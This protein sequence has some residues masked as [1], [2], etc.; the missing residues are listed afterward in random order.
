MRF[1]P[2]RVA[3]A[4]TVLYR[5]WVRSM[6]FQ[7]SNNLDRIRAC[8][9][10][11]RPILLAIWHEELFALTGFGT[12]F[13]SG[14][15][16]TVVSDSRDGELIAQVLRR[17]GFATARGSSTRGGLKALNQLRRHMIDGRIGV[18]T[19]D[20]PRGPRQEAKDGAVYLAQKAG[21][22]LFPVRSRP[23]SAYV[24]KRSWDHF[25]LPL[26]F[27]ACEVHFGEPL[28]FASGKMSAEELHQGSQRLA[29]ALHDTLSIR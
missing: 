8:L 2:A 24:F 20:G 19:V 27:C 5:L 21:A 18:I 1:D 3:P 6:R 11:G 22:L 12:T 15:L 25:Q 10:S 23:S 4:L 7:Y 9:D 28:E 26:P 13:L 16:A 29:Q 14:R 17:I